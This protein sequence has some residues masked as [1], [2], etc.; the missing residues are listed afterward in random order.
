[1]GQRS[2]KCSFVALFLFFSYTVINMSNSQQLFLGIHINNERLPFTFA[3][4][5]SNRKILALEQGRMEEV[6]AFA[7]GENLALVGINAASHLNCG[8][9]KKEEV[10]S[11]FSQVPPPGRW[12]NLRAVEYELYCQGD[13]VTRTPNGIGDCPEWVKLGLSLYA[14]LQDLGFTTYSNDITQ[15]RYCEVP[16]DSVYH[17]F[18]G[19]TPW[20]S[21][22][23][24]GRIQRQLALVEEGVQ[25]QDP[26]ETFEEVTRFRLLKGSF[27]FTKVLSCKQL[28]AL[29][30]A[31]VVW[32][33]G[34]KPGRTECLGEDQEGKIL[35]PVKKENNF[36][37]YN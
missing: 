15:H 3:L 7:S 30:A 6:L 11:Q 27:P 13:R 14:N 5:D 19:V 26:M 25:V 31:L 29:G 2:L 28:S 34:S 33:A 18:L 21:S 22:S 17:R 1:M 36:S 12:T 32:L 9:M 8:L 20:I 16:V 37:V 23:L 24:E 35:L 10:R 4:M